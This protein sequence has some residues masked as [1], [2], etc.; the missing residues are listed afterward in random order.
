MDIPAPVASPNNPILSGSKSSHSSTDSS[1]SHSAFSDSLDDKVNQLNKTQQNNSKKQPERHERAVVDKGE[2]A[3]SVR[4]D[5]SSAK[6]MNEESADIADENKHYSSD[7][8]SIKGSE[9]DLSQ[10]LTASSDV[11]NVQYQLGAGGVLPRGNGL[12]LSEMGNEFITDSVVASF[13]DQ[14]EVF[15]DFKA[16]DSLAFNPLGNLTAEHSLQETAKRGVFP[17]AEFAARGSASNAGVASGELDFN[18]MATANKLSELMALKGNEQTKG[19]AQLGQQQVGLVPAANSLRH[20]STVDFSLNVSAAQL[21][22]GA[23][24]TAKAVLSVDS[25]VNSSRWAGDLGKNIQ[26]MVNQSI[27]G[28]QIRLN[29]QQLGPIEIRLQMENGQATIAFTAQHAATREAIDAAMPRLREMLTDQ[30]VDLVDVNVSQHSFAEQQQQQQSD[31][32]EALELSAPSEELAVNPL[33]TEENNV[34]V[35]SEGLVN[36]YV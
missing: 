7:N 19:L 28:A 26:W 22:M 25:P 17:M 16:T 2:G 23:D 31:S 1:S 6:N 32:P 12:P 18:V 14:P 13:G 34:Q 3:N 21:P 36:E 9:V 27:N 5:K 10:H 24:V 35:A 33:F 15:A 30:G 8:E 11:A 20:D 29:P 4:S